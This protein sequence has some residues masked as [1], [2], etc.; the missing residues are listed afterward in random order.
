M[1]ILSYHVPTYLLRKV[2]VKAFRQQA[3]KERCELDA[4]LRPI[5]QIWGYAFEVLAIDSLLCLDSPVAVHTNRSADIPAFYLAPGLSLVSELFDKTVS[6]YPKDNIIYVSRVGLNF[7][8][9]FVVSDNRNNVA[10]LQMT[11]AKKHI[12]KH[13]SVRSV[14][15]AFTKA[16]QP[17]TNQVPMPKDWSLIYVTPDEQ[18]RKTADQK[19]LALGA[20]YPSVDVGWLHIG[21][22]FK[23]LMQKLAEADDEEAASGAVAD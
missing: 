4:F 2:L 13:S 7:L 10:I 8:D 12:L 14:L 19:S 5:P 9:V 6:F 20:G 3:L 16:S 21:Q 18:G 23:S 17:T 15:E 11:V 1:P 22:E